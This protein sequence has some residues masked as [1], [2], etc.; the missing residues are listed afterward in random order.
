MKKL[1]TYICGMILIAFYVFSPLSSHAATI[2]RFDYKEREECAIFLVGPIEQGDLSKLELAY[3]EYDL[4]RSEMN[5]QY[6]QDDDQ[7]IRICLNSDGGALSE[8]IK[9]ARFLIDNGMGS[10]V[11]E[12]ASCQ[13]ACAVAFMGGTYF[14]EDDRGPL[15]FRVIYPSSILGFH[16][17]SLNIPDSN[18]SAKVVKDAYATALVSV[19]QIEDIA[20]D[21]AFP[22]SLLIE[23]LKTNPDDMLIVDRVEQAVRWGI[24][25]ASVQAIQPL[26]SDLVQVGCRNIDA[27]E[28]DASVDTEVWPIDSSDSEVFQL[29]KESATEWSASHRDYRQEAWS[30]CELSYHSDVKRYSYQ[31]KVYH[32]YGYIS[33]RGNLTALHFYPSDARL[34][35]LPVNPDF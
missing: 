23:M 19:A 4:H 26:T 5:P 31:S 3:D 7:H 13:S 27:N 30:T 22:R 6:W 32:G 35:T 24:I 33:G 18:Y 15:P 12:S 20:T 14:P 28:L 8:G 34:E 9:I 21:G 11:L 10:V 2:G 25:V 1:K 29:T 17:P 16:A